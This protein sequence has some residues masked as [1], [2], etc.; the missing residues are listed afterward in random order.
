MPHTLCLLLCHFIFVP[1]LLSFDAV[2]WPCQMSNIINYC[3][4]FLLFWFLLFLLVMEL[5]PILS[6]ILLLFTSYYYFTGHC[7]CRWFSLLFSNWVIL[8]FFLPSISGIRDVLV[9]SPCC[10]CWQWCYWLEYDAACFIVS[11]AIGRW[12]RYSF[13]FMYYVFPWH[14]YLNTAICAIYFVLS[15]LFF[16]LLLLLC[17]HSSIMCY[18]FCRCLV[19]LYLLPPIIHFVYYYSP[20]IFLIDDDN[21]IIYWIGYVGISCNY[22]STAATAV[23][24]ERLLILYCI[25]KSVVDISAKL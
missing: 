16:V 8:L 19:L 24:G 15:S 25:W 1:T 10:C 20:Y 14:R 2:L 17:R 5:T 13:Y 18:Y 12:I 7:Q 3:C 23:A 22:I 11:I 21:I 6:S 9:R 4:F